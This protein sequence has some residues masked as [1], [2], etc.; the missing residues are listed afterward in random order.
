MNVYFSPS[1]CLLPLPAPLV[2]FF[3]SFSPFLRASPSCCTVPLAPLFFLPP[4]SSLLSPSSP[5]SRSGLRHIFSSVFWA[6]Q[7]PRSPSPSP[8]MAPLSP[9]P[10][11]VTALCPELRPPCPPRKQAFSPTPPEPLPPLPRVAGGKSCGAAHPPGAGCTGGSR[12]WSQR[13]RPPPLPTP[14]PLSHT[15]WLGALQRGARGLA[16]ERAR[17]ATA[18]APRPPR[19]RAR[20]TPHPS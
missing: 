12:V 9:V 6:G 10:P 18:P 17:A 4:P 13:G 15:G 2:C 3:F 19:W 8:D 16:D 7:P 1:P 5:Y 20:G 14:T 11:P